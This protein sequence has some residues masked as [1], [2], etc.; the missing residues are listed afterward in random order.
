[1]KPR[2]IRNHSFLL[3]IWRDPN[4]VAAPE[5]ALWRAQIQHV[6]SGNSCYVDELSELIHFLEEWA[7]DLAESHPVVSQLK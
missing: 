4:A 3:R 5:S 6:Q 2:E 1:M 7:G